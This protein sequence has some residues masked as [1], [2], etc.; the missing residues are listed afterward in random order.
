[1][2]LRLYLRGL[3]LVF[4]VFYFQYKLSIFRSQSKI[5][6]GSNDKKNKS[7]NQNV[8][9]WHPPSQGSHLNG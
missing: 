1:M 5:M 3:N 7:S 4:K 6:S 2:I 9:I 8:K